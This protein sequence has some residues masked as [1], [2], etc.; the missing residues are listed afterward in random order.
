MQIYAAQVLAAATLLVQVIAQPQDGASTSRNM[1][2]CLL[3][4]DEGPC[5]AMLPQYY[6]D[7]YT[8]TCQEFLYGGCGGNDNNFET[9]EDC[10]KTCWKIKK[11]PKICRMEPEEGRCRAYLKRY[12]FNLMTMA[13]EKFIFTGC[14]GNDNNFRDEASCLEKC[15]PKRNAPSFCYSPKDEGS[16]SASVPR[17]YFN[18]ES[19]ACEEFTYTGC[20]GN[21]N[22]FV[23]IEDCNK[24][25]K[26]G[27][28]KPRNRNRIRKMKTQS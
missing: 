25:C 28:K 14:Y 13:C 21:S 15:S 18:I 11:V 12:A 3:P 9:L 22:N 23:R 5:K 17:F 26:K 27:N 4:M 6:Y 7:R 20:G 24:V 1:T 8:Q 2:A 19:K 10:E 16:C